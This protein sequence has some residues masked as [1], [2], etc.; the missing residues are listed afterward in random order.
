MR[1]PKH[2]LGP[3]NAEAAAMAEQSFRL[4]HH[5]TASILSNGGYLT[6]RHETLEAARSDCARLEKETG[7]YRKALVYAVTQAGNTDLIPEW[8][9][10]PVA[11]SA[12]DRS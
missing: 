10:P 4:A 2:M 1:I 6:S 9:V 8:F 12:G 5:F 3:N 7:N 11:A